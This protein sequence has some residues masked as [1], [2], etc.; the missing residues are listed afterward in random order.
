MS[1]SLLR[2]KAR[3]GIW[4]PD[5]A[6]RHGL[7]TS[8]EVNGPPTIRQAACGQEGCIGKL[9]YSDCSYCPDHTTGPYSSGP[10]RLVGYTSLREVGAVPGDI[11]DTELNDYCK[12]CHG[13]KG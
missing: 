10:V 12:C 13:G 5:L 7:I 1:D 11:F 3:E 4:D 9:R 6:L 2:A 8:G